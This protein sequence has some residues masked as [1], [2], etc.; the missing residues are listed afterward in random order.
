ML[1]QVHFVAIN[2]TTKAFESGIQVVRHVVFQDFVRIF[3]S[4][5]TAHNEVRCS[6]YIT[7]AK[8]RKVQVMTE[9]KTR[10]DAIVMP[11]RRHL[12][13]IR[14]VSFVRHIYGTPV[15]RN[16][17]FNPGKRLYS[18]N[19]HLVFRNNITISGNTTSVPQMPPFS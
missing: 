5:Q 17:D 12:I 7:L 2:A 16:L 3:E 11:W 10:G 4:C 15:P 13:S 9:S 14:Q 18:G 1:P 8:V 19:T 6:N